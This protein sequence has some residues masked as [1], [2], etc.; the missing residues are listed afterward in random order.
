M[1]EILN[2]ILSA[3]TLQKT[4]TIVRNDAL[5]KY[6]LQCGLKSCVGLRGMCCSGLWHNRG[7]SIQSSNG[8]WGWLDLFFTPRFT[9]CGQS[10]RGPLLVLCVSNSNISTMVRKGCLGNGDLEF[11]LQTKRVA[12]CKYSFMSYK[13]LPLQL[14]PDQI[15]SQYL[16][17]MYQEKNLLDLS[18]GPLRNRKSDIL[19][20]SRQS[21]SSS[22]S[23]VGR[24]LLKLSSIATR[25]ERSNQA[26]SFLFADWS[27]S[28]FNHETHS[29]FDCHP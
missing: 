12:A 17:Q 22:D 19:N 21:W 4:S 11:A 10:T 26:G 29:S 28:E 9:T 20:S 25:S 7:K 16:T 2:V 1:L 8:L 14:P 5:K 6:I 3:C 18:R 15:L 27:L 24:V 23:V 13:R